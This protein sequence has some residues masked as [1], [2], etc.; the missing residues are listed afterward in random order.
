MPNPYD[1]PMWLT[2]TELARRGWAPVAIRALVPER[3]SRRTNGMRQP[4]YHRSQVEAVLKD[5]ALGDWTG[6]FDARFW[7]DPSMR[8]RI[9]ALQMHSRPTAEAD[10]E[11][12][13]RQ[14]RTP[15]DQE[16]QGLRKAPDA[17]MPMWL[18]EAELARRG[19]APVAIRALIPEKLVLRT[20]GRRQPLYHRSQI[21]AV[22]RDP[23]LSDWTGRSDSRFWNDPSMR[24]R[25]RSLHLRSRPTAE[26]DAERVGRQLRAAGATN[27]QESLGLRKTPDG[28]KKERRARV[29]QEQAAAETLRRRQEKLRRGTERDVAHAQRTGT[30]SSVPAGVSHP[31]ELKPA[32]RPTKSV[33]RR[34]GTAPSPPAAAPRLPQ[35]H[36]LAPIRQRDPVPATTSQALSAAGPCSEASS[37]EYRR[38][39]E[40]VERRQ[41]SARG[42]R[43]ISAA[44]PLRIQ[45]ARD[46]V[47]RRCMGR[48]ENPGCGGQPGDVTDKGDA[49]LEV[50]H[51]A[52][53]AGGGEDHPAHMVA[54]CPNCHAIKTRGSGRK[55]LQVAL[56]AVARRAHARA[57]TSTT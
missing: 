46:A 34:A 22:L 11:R 32:P 38:L 41:E 21:E 26:A 28:E 51:V 17:K 9:Q 6:R 54:L 23:A 27:D 37:L 30:A 33:T 55:A 45:A 10:A 15:D 18:T 4:L 48:C 47:M 29:A 7:N 52:D 16:V 8:Q 25:L 40:L 31:T 35:A 42:R 50:D 56:F 36:V 12:V 43:S 44:R 57:M 53:L 5:P 39:V 2:E 3:L 1:M 24:Q 14:L 13:D 49:I 19:W 20:D